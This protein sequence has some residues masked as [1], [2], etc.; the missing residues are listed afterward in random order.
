MSTSSY[1]ALQKQ[2][3][4]ISRAMRPS[5]M[6]AFQAMEKALEPFRR[7]HLAIMEQFK[8]SNTAAHFQ[9][10]AR[11]NQQMLASFDRIKL[12]TRLIDDLTK[13]HA[14]WMPGVLPAQDQLTHLQAS[15][16]LALVASSQITSSAERLYAGIDFDKLQRAFRV[17]AEVVAQFHLRVR[18]LTRGFD[19]LAR[20]VEP[21][22]D[23]TVLPSFVL[24][25]SS[26][27]M[28]VSG[29][30]VVELASEDACVEQAQDSEVLS[31]IREET[32]GAVELLERID[33]ELANAYLG[34]RDASTSGN[35]DRGR[36][37]LASLREMWG[38]LLRHL[39]PDEKVLSWLDDKSA[40]LVHEGR[41]TRR[42]RF[43]YVCRGINHGPLTEFLDLDT[44]ALVKLM[45]LFNRVH[46]LEPGLTD[47]QLSALL[48]RTDS[49]LR[50]FIQIA[51]EGQ[52]C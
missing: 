14:S 8:A 2:F 10:I 51:E 18:A 46:Q 1:L 26:R 22:P 7:N 16:K 15:V 48:L 24:P 37:V 21:L 36:H 35:I 44:R 29:H 13:V 6:D 45:E 31:E 47:S 3:A 20:S 32:S 50:F 38:H 49:Y 42:A 4:Q 40:E 11:A 30:V 9:D 12:D 41:P 34:A 43:F 27:E 28:F 23:L 39:A 25:S 17:S 52:E 5:Y 19:E 33:P